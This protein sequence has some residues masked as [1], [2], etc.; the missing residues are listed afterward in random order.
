MHQ[1]NVLVGASSFRCV[2]STV[3][4]DCVRRLHRLRS[5]PNQIAFATQSDCVRCTMTYLDV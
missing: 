1:A 3:R 2:V 5:P 4:S